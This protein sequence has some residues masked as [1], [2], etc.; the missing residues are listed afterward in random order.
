MSPDYISSGVYA[1]RDQPLT[2]SMMERLVL[3]TF[4]GQLQRREVIASTILGIHLSLGGA[5]PQAEDLPRSLKKS[6]AQLRKKGLAENPSFGYWRIG[7]CDS[8]SDNNQTEVGVPVPPDPQPDIT[9]DCI[10]GEGTSAIYL[11]YF[12]T[13]R[14]QAEEHGENIWA[15]KIGRTDRD[16]LLRVLAQTSTALPERP[17]IAFLIRT[18]YPLAWEAALHGVLTLR[19][20]RIETAPGSEWF[21]TSP[22]EVL[23]L[24]R[25]FDPSL[26]MS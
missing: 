6:L 3:A 7:L 11:Y 1:Y 24:A 12:S 20:R 21:N 4:A 10:L 17:I 18:P 26:F 13:Y 8:E 22:N 19:G 15:C 23:D 2:P 5:A 9:I 25:C 14:T 16:P